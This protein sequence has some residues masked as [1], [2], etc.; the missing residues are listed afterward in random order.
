MTRRAGE[1]SER[2][3]AEEVDRTRLTDV[4][5][6]Q[7]QWQATFDAVTDYIVV[8]NAERTIRKVNV[9]FAARFGKHPRE[10]IGMKVSD[11]FQMSLPHDNCVIDRAIMSNSVVIDEVGVDGEIYL[12]SIFPA[13]FGEEQVYVGILKNMT[14]MNRM[15]DQFY[16][17]HKLVSLGQLVSGVAHE[18]NNPLTGIL[19]LTELMLRKV[20]DES[21][22]AG[23]DK[24]RK[25]AERCAEIVDSLLCFSR[26]QV[27]QH[28]LAHLNYVIDRTAAM[29]I[30]WFRKRGIEI[31]KH[32]GDLPGVCVDVPQIQQVF[33]NLFLNAEEAIAQ[34]GTQGRITVTTSHDEGRSCITAVIADNGTG[35]KSSDLPRIFD[36][37]FSTKSVGHGPGLGLSIAYGLI[38]EHGGTIAVDSKEGEGTTVTIEL[39]VVKDGGGPSSCAT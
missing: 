25:A 19:G 12:T 31:V 38:S 3:R 28:S 15:R 10:I 13:L 27:P 1:Q 7:R 24:I 16:H 11:L 23:L 4:A 2:T 29:R 26:Q 22:R 39:P 36:P 17:A 5:K 8:F 33:L 14:E 6:S 9:S 21:V 32:Y 18:L 37:F 30:Y 34:A 20:P 35:I